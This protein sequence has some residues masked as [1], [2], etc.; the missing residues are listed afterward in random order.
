MEPWTREVEEEL[1]A[2]ARLA[3]LQVPERPLPV[4]VKEPDGGAQGERGRPPRTGLAHLTLE[5]YERWAA[6]Y[7]GPAA[8]LEHALEGAQAMS[9]AQAVA[10]VLRQGQMQGTLDDWVDDET[11]RVLYGP[12][13]EVPW[14]PPVTQVEPMLAWTYPALKARVLGWLRTWPSTA[15]LLPSL[16]QAQGKL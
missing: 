14:C 13:P 10:E 12:E 3:A 7:P 8:A 4:S 11:L 1:Q 6:T 15:P 5:A 9:E 2:L 16:G